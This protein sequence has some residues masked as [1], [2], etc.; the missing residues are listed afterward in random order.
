MLSRRDFL[1]VAAKAGVAA[2]VSACRTT[3]PAASGG[4][5]VNDVHSHLNPTRVRD[6]VQ[7]D[8]VQGIQKVIRDARV[9]GRGVSVAG[10]RHAMGGQQ[11]GTDTTLID[12]N[13]M[14]RVLEFD[15]E[16]GEIEVEAGLQWPELYK[17]LLDTQRGS[18]SAWSFIQ[19][20][21]GA[22]KL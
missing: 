13:G 11:F 14:T 2:A 7:P 9:E 10:G 19:K 17:Y 22:D 20:Q 3:S 5:V 21:T 6:V 12:M 8:S 16:R 4:V 1:Q 15:R 18:S